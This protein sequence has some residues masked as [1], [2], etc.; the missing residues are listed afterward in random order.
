MKIDFH[1]HTKKTKKDVKNSKRELKLDQYEKYIELRKNN[2][3]GV[4]AIT[5]HNV[6]DLEQYE[7]L[8]KLAGEDIMFL[9]GV[10]LDVFNEK[11]NKKYSIVIL[12]NP[13]FSDQFN[14]F[15]LNI[16]GNYLKENKH[17]NLEKLFV[18]IDNLNEIDLMFSTPLGKADSEKK[19][20]KNEYE[21]IDKYCIKKNFMHLAEVSHYKKNNAKVFSENNLIVV[22]GSDSNDAINIDYGKLID[23]KFVDG[24]LL[25]FNGLKKMLE[26]HK[27]HNLNNNEKDEEEIKIIENND[28]FNTKVYKG[29]NLILGSYASGKSSIIKQIKDYFS[30]KGNNVINSIYESNNVDEE[31]DEF[32]KKLE[33]AFLNKLKD[34]LSSYSFLLLNDDNLKNKMENINIS[35]N[36]FKK[37]WDDYKESTKSKKTF[38]NISKVSVNFFY[39]KQWESFFKKKDLNNNDIDNL[40]MDEII[41]NEKKIDTIINY[42]E[43]M[44]NNENF[45]PKS[46]Y[47]LGNS[48]AFWKYFMN[49]YE[50]EIDKNS[51]VKLISNLIDTKKKQ[52]SYINRLKIGFCFARSLYKFREASNKII[53]KNKAINTINDFG[54]FNAFEKIY[55]LK[56][57]ISKVISFIN[58]KEIKEEFLGSININ[59]SECLKIKF[60]AVNNKKKGIKACLG[61]K[62][63]SENFI[64][65]IESLNNKK[66]YKEFIDHFIN[67][68]LN[69]DNIDYFFN[70][71]KNNIIYSLFGYY[72]EYYN[73]NR[74]LE[75]G[76]SSGQ[77]KLLSIHRYLEKDETFYF[78]DE[79]EMSL[80]SKT[81]KE[82]IF[83]KIENKISHENYIFIATHN[84]NIA[85]LSMA[86][87]VILKIN[88][89]NEYHLFQGRTYQKYL[90]NVNDKSKKIVLNKH[91]IDLFEGGNKMFGDRR[92]I[93]NG[94]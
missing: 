46:I 53:S 23:Y 14:K 33:S 94:K 62:Q 13:I 36:S 75:N 22:S 42:L 7:K 25:G 29:L 90:L 69:D 74:L 68:F 19:F 10:E 32:I 45:Y 4:I 64:K 66:E 12:C 15:V 63:K 37:K 89:N 77:K 83:D 11:T 86:N 41:I 65:F 16:S 9:P 87:N 80:D 21:Y 24:P 52:R 30:K 2:N 40:F 60:I 85:L 79:P 28:K 73:N 26:I 47:N 27:I 35:I 48:T 43:K 55:L 61:D 5:N 57:D 6:F 1:S 17:I 93:Y 49:F 81:I 78:L 39:L 67:K 18:E 20:D 51:I 44:K 59:G 38:F 91:F 54:L 56:K 82:N 58:E 31:H 88:K 34:K 70:K 50:K 72:S 3:V 76:L 92:K 71:N 84:P 8:E